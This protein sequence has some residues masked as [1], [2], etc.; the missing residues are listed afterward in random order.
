MSPL[1]PAE[2]W[3]GKQSDDPLR[4]EYLDDIRSKVARALEGHRAAQRPDKAAIAQLEEVVAG[5]NA[6]KEELA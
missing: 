4:G 5:L 6:M 3:A 2:L 1:T